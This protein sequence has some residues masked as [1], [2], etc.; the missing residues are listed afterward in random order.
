MP[1]TKSEGTL[2]LLRICCYESYLFSAVV[3]VSEKVIFNGWIQILKSSVK[4]L[5]ILESLYMNMWIVIKRYIKSI[6]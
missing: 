6:F 2:L 5:L 4:Q 3:R 1:H